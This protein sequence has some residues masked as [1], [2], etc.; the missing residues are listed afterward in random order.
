MRKIRKHVI[1]LLVVIFSCF[2]QQVNLIAQDLPDSHIKELSEFLTVN[3]AEK[4][5][6]HTD[7]EIYSVHDSIWFKIYLTDAHTNLPQKGFQS[8]YVELI[9]TTGN[10]KVRNLLITFNGFGKGDFDLS[11]Y[12]LEKG[13]YQLRAYTD[14]QRNYGDD[15]LFCKNILLSGL[16][17]DLTPP[18]SAGLEPKSGNKVTEKIRSI[19]L[20]FLPEGGYLSFGCPCKLAFIA[21]DANNQPVSVSGWILNG[22]NAKIAQFSTVHNG[23]GSIV[24]TPEKGVNYKATL[25][26]IPAYSV[27]LPKA[28]DKVQFSVTATNDS[29]YKLTLRRPETVKATENYYLICSSKGRVNFYSKINL[30]EALKKIKIGPKGLEPGINKLTLT[31]SLM[32]PVAERLIFFRKE[33]FFTVLAKSDRDEY[34]KR[35]K[36]V[37]DISTMQS[38]KAIPANLSVSVVN[39]TQVKDLEEYP[40]NILSYL[41][42]DSELHGSI[43]NPSYYFKDDSTST[44][45]NLDLV[46]LTNG[47]R[48][49]IWNDYQDSLP[50]TKYKKEVGLEVNGK[51][52]KLFGQNEVVDGKVSLFIASKKGEISFH[53]TQSDSTGMF[54]FPPIFF[55]DSVSAFLQGRNKNQK[56]NIEVINL[57][58]FRPAAPVSFNGRSFPVPGEEQQFNFNKMANLRLVEDKAYHPEKYE[59]MIDQIDI[60]KN[61]KKE[62]DNYL[63]D[64]F[65]AISSAGN[66]VKIAEDKLS[67]D[68]QGTIVTNVPGAMASG[69]SFTIR[70]KAPFFLVN[71]IPR[72]FEYANTIPMSEIYTIEIINDAVSMSMHD[73]MNEGAIVSIYTKR[74]EKNAQKEYYKGIITEKLRGYYQSRKFYSPNYE[75]SPTDRP[76]HRATI[77]WN[78]DIISD[79]EGKAKFSFYTTDDPGSMLLR[80][81]GIS[82]DGKPGV[83]FLKINKA[84]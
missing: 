12:H 72:D 11:L 41:L 17:T 79:S 22:S 51:I 78:P 34:A 26:H 68:L 64:K 73:A 83:G 46:M 70:G 67:L 52:K 84:N 27:Q 80:I 74:G 32:R 21:R 49:Y 28:T 5:Y 10:I 38:D 24:F 61:N 81:E 59:I 65:R 75:T 30:A 42:L 16:K 47:W 69:D 6:L 35:E 39:S 44:S 55:P 53:E 45:E 2:F 50:E 82:N 20:Q 71:D 8:V 13:K 25:D 48:N 15:L 56:K 40:Q 54:R 76:D 57:A 66:V 58:S 23:M 29:V 43:P 7:R 9:D 77:Y 3:P 37:V 62:S 33:N 36:V 19:D 60:V 14:Y 31:D 63:N 4:V 18:N 1:C